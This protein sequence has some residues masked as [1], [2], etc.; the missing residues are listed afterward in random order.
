MPSGKVGLWHVPN[1]RDLD[2]W[3]ARH[4]HA[5]ML[6]FEGLTFDQIGIRLGVGR[7]RASQMV[8]RY[9]RRLRKAMRKTRF[10]FERF[11]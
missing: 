2:Y 1:V 11:S 7:C 3:H 6:R 5:A 9:A 4:E 8:W 10:H